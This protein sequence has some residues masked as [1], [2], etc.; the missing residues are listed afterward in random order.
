[1]EILKVV[2]RAV[3]KVEMM[4]FDSVGEMAVPMVAMKAAQKVDL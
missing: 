3:W 2:M 1:M 4:D